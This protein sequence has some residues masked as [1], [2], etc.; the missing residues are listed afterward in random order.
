[1]TPK[2]S[3]NVCCSISISKNLSINDSLIRPVG[4]M[5]YN[6]NPDLET[7]YRIGKLLLTLTQLVSKRSQRA[8]SDLG[9]Y[10]GRARNTVT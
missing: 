5:V 9:Q 1:M 2:I 8:G 6:I 7:T 10:C 4:N 3:L